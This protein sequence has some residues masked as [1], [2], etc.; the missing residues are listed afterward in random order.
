VTEDTSRQKAVDSPGTV[1]NQD[2]CA[3]LLDMIPAYSIGAADP[4]ECAFVKAHLAECPDAAAELVSYAALRNV[5]QVSAPIVEPPAALEARLLA[6]AAATREKLKPAKLTPPRGRRWQ[7]ASLALAAAALV[8]L[9][10]NIYWL[11]QITALQQQV[12]RAS[13]GIDQQNAVL[14]MVAS[15]NAIPIALANGAPASPDRPAATMLCDP[16]GVV[17]L[18]DVQHFPV[19]PMDKA[20]Q[21]W[22][23]EAGQ[24]LSVRQFRVRDDGT[25]TLTIQAAQTLRHF[26]SVWITAEGAAGSTTPTT[27]PV[28]SGAIHY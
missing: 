12:Q 5:L 21:V 14:Q 25:A 7:P 28:V 23:V 26:D 20:Y 22:L 15:G 2:T 11:V 6:A 8:L 19:L 1:S 4:E 3:R 17:G 13:A 18:L 10:G 16:D 24:Y 27:P 9:I